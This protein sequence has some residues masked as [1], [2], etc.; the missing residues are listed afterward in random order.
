[1]VSAESAL[2]SVT[3]TTARL[4]S[5]IAV[6]GTWPTRRLQDPEFFGALARD[7]PSSRGW[8]VAAAM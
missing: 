2:Y 4:G 1:M 5:N 3:V 6:T 8:P 7:R